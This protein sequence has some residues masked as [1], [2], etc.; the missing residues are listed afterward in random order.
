MRCTWHERHARTLTPSQ[1]ACWPDATAPCTQA[2][3]STSG[4]LY[5]VFEYV[6]YTLLGM[7][8]AAPSGRGLPGS[9]MKSIMWQL[10][11]SL[12]FMHGKKVRGGSMRAHSTN[13]Q[14]ACG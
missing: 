2:Y 14:L 13:A 6:E 1:A 11:Q 9:Q 12:S 10:L 8:K 4:R 5:L 3:Q 7:L